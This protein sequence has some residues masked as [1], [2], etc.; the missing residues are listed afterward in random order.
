MIF[1][2]PEQRRYYQARLKWELDENTRLAAEAAAREESERRGRSEGR[3][4]GRLEGRAEGRLEGRV[5]GRVEGQSH[6]RIR[7]IQALRSL[8]GQPP[9]DETALAALDFDQLGSM[10]A[11]LQLQIHN[12]MN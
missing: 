3:V 11:D 1:R 8:L 9:L 2:Q 10:V 4:E 12:R 6:E 5:E 7:M